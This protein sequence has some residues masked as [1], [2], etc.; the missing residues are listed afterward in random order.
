MSQDLKDTSAGLRNADHAELESLRDQLRTLSPE[1][2]AEPA[3]QEPRVRAR[4]DEC[5][6]GVTLVAHNPDF[7]DRSL[8]RSQIQLIVI[9]K[10]EGLGIWNLLKDGTFLQ[11]FVK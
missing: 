7:F 3:C 5:T 9:M 1:R 4:F 10:A 8:P 2:L 11:E 6:A